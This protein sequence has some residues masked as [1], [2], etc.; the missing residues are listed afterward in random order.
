MLR[1]FKTPA[2]LLLSVLLLTLAY[3]PIG[4]FY[5]AWIGLVPWLMVLRNTRRLRAVFAWSW[6]G[7]ILFFS[8]NMWWLAFVTGPGVLALVMV[9]GL[10]WGLAGWLIRG[11]G[12][13]TPR[14]GVR[15]NAV[16]AVLLIGMV[17]AAFE[18][19]RGWFATGL[20]W[21][22]IGHTQSNFLPMCQI[23]D[24]MGVYGV[25]FWVVALNVL[26]AI[27]F[28]W[29]KDFTHMRAAIGGMAALLIAFLG[30]GLWRMAETPNC[31]TPGPLVIVV[32]SNYPQSNSG[33]KGADIVDIVGFHLTETFK[34]LQHQ[35]ADLVVWSETMVPAINRETREA[36]HNSPESLPQQAYDE[37]GK[38]ARITHTPIVVGSNYDAQWTEITRV[39]R[40]SKVLMPAERHN[41]A[42]LFEKTGRLSEARYDKIHT[43]PFGEYTPFKHSCPP[44]YRF[45]LAFNP[46]ENPDANELAAGP[47][48]AL[49]VFQLPV[50][51]PRAAPVR[52]VTPICF[53][54]ID[55][56]LVARMFRPAGG[57]GKRADLLI[58]LT[59]DG[60]FRDNQ[61]PQHLQV[62]VFRSIENRV[63]TA[64]SV[65]TGISGFIDSAGRIGSTVPQQVPGTAAQQVMLDS[66]LTFYT[67]YGDVFA[68]L[69]ALISSVLAVVATGRWWMNRT[70]KSQTS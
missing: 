52:F 68:W 20:P 19:L 30:Y 42:Y 16:R 26:L 60:W 38:L 69:C 27:I 35:P 36:F 23:A 53:E 70:G 57:G 29:R 13:L 11:S 9:L 37:I 14:D 50:D 45:F 55:A 33:Q 40:E 64:R 54:D 3:A 2:L 7:G 28:F 44:L 31:F 6:L 61:M 43:V 65:N 32:Q 10:Y 21:L 41:S 63:P 58:N 34:A 24:V 1:H 46:Y 4:Q 39:T 8:A 48:D 25:S 18:W 67:R 22:F 51:K 62:A 47:E 15:P 17:W 49:T 66:R 59:N 56:A 5:L 12:L